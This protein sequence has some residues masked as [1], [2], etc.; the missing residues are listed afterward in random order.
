MVSGHA[1]RHRPLSARGAW[2]LVDVREVSSAGNQ[3]LFHEQD[4]RPTC[5]VSPGTLP[6]VVRKGEDMSEPDTAAWVEELARHE[7]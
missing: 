3:A 2:G 1:W 5:R 4:N 7:C 6:A